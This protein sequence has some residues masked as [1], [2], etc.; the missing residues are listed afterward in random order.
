M[1]EDSHS[2]VESLQN[3]IEDSKLVQ[4]NQKHF[5]EIRSLKNEDDKTENFLKLEWLSNQSVRTKGQDVINP[6][7]LISPNSLTS[8]KCE[9]DD[10]K[11][12]IFHSI[13]SLLT[14]GITNSQMTSN[15]NK[16]ESNSINYRNQIHQQ[17]INFNKNILTK[18][19][20]IDS[21]KENI[22]A[23]KS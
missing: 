4:K 1:N 6:S 17:M 20:N 14:A 7:I 15:E 5:N 13:T 18:N 2:D 10:R 3:S 9:T 19:A 11:Q 22:S 23:I 16:N 21:A 8:S 12:R